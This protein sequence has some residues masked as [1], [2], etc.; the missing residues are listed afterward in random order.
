MQHS[1]H[2]KATYFSR[3]VVEGADINQEHVGHRLID[4][5]SPEVAGVVRNQEFNPRFIDDMT[6]ED[7]IDW[8]DEHIIFDNKG[9]LIG[10]ID[11]GELLWKAA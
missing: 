5:L 2:D 4:S 8:V 11:H 3:F 10:V 9:N 1:N 7:V 6:L